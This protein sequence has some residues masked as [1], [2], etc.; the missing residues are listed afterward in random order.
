MA[1]KPSPASGSPGGCCPLFPR[2]MG[3]DGGII[4]ELRGAGCVAFNGK[5]G[6]PPQLSG[7][8]KNIIVEQPTK[9]RAGDIACENEPWLLSGKGEAMLQLFRHERRVG[10]C[11]AVDERSYA[12]VWIDKKGRGGARRIDVKQTKNG[13]LQ[14]RLQGS[15]RKDGF[16]H[17]G[18]TAPVMAHLFNLES[19]DCSEKFRIRA[20]PP[21]RPPDARKES[22]DRPTEKRAKTAP[23]S[24]SSPSTP[25][26]AVA[27]PVPVPPPGPPP[28]AVGLPPPPPPPQVSSTAHADAAVQIQDMAERLA[29]RIRGEARK[30]A[31]GLPASA[32]AWSIYELLLAEESGGGSGHRELRSDPQRG[33]RLETEFGPLLVETCVILLV[34]A[35]ALTLFAMAS[36]ILDLLACSHWPLATELATE[37]RRLGDH[38]TGVGVGG[39]ALPSPDIWLRLRSDWIVTSRWKEAIERHGKKYMR[40]RYRST[41]MQMVLLPVVISATLAFGLVP[42]WYASLFLNRDSPM[43]ACLQDSRQYEQARRYASVRYSMR[44]EQ[45]LAT[46]R[47]LQCLDTHPG[48]ANF[49]R[50]H[51]GQKYSAAVWSY[52]CSRYC[53]QNSAD[54][55][56][57]VGQCDWLRSAWPCHTSRFE[58]PSNQNS[59]I[60]KEVCHLLSDPAGDPDCQLPVGNA[61]KCK[62]RV[63]WIHELGLEKCR[64][65]LATCHQATWTW[66]LKNWVLK[67]LF[68]SFNLCWSVLFYLFVFVAVEH[69]RERPFECTPLSM[70]H[71]C[72]ATAPYQCPVVKSMALWLERLRAQARGGQTLEPIPGWEGWGAPFRQAWDFMTDEQGR[73]RFQ[74]FAHMPV[75]DIEGSGFAG[76]AL[77]WLYGCWCVWDPRLSSAPYGAQDVMSVD[78]HPS[79]V[80]LSWGV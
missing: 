48:W 16:D 15:E 72:V 40:S 33:A 65:R 52:N 74:N 49:A 17:G 46:E 43:A 25:P 7:V 5:G 26:T 32:L 11:A 14:F 6:I 59:P 60:C 2:E 1:Q 3:S 41:A 39:P 23:C 58:Y 42:G 53:D 67:F 37:R 38:I 76:L 20:A 77:F 45:K 27:Q 64:P 78:L 34:F 19:S 8:K 4:A 55:L 71:S 75:Y 24:A 21:K 29:P 36:P 69:L 9:H 44:D 63:D 50:D 61:M 31:A 57:V 22:E 79:P 73:W 68:V 56:T 35:A 51:P 10:E 70:Q 66:A 62:A 12:Y 80:W 54:T 28:S 47:F 30:L 13:R 18:W